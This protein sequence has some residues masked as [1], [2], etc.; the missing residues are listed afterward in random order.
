MLVTTLHADNSSKLYYWN[1][2][3]CYIAETGA[4]DYI[5]VFLWCHISEVTQYTHLS[6]HFI[7]INWT[8]KQNAFSALT[9]LAGRQEE[10]LACKNWVM[11][12]WCGYLSAARCRFDYLHM[13]QLMP[14]YPKTPSSPASVKSRP[15]YLSGTGLPRLSWKRG[16]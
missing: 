9:L 11:R 1:G 10:H 5:S 7:T 3:T 15:V 8:N 16:R 12:C 4:A 14:L 6:W 13:V 2:A